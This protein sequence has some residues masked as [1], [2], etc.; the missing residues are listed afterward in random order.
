MVLEIALATISDLGRKAGNR[1]SQYQRYEE[2]SWVTAD[3]CFCYGAKAAR[4]HFCR[5]RRCSSASASRA[6]PLLLVGNIRA[7]D[8]AAQAHPSFMSSGDSKVVVRKHK[9]LPDL[10]VIPFSHAVYC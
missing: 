4:S 6:A 5:L 1:S 9:H 2:R 8:L 10:T 7:C 3:L